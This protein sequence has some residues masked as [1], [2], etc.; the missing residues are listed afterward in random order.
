[1]LR[2]YGKQEDIRALQRV[3]AVFSTFSSNRIATL[4]EVQLTQAMLSDKIRA[5]LS[6]L[7]KRRHETYGNHQLTQ[8]FY[9]ERASRWWILTTN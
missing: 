8:T 4:I 5:F 2:P 3:I 9:F 1:M 6:K 7:M